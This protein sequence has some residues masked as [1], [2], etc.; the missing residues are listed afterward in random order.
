MIM[1]CIG[2]R[3]CVNTRKM[4]NFQKH[5]AHVNFVAVAATKAAFDL[6]SL[7]PLAT[8]T[9]T[10]KHLTNMY[11][12]YTE[13]V[14]NQFHGLNELYNGTLNE[15][16]HCL[17]STN[18]SSNECYTFRNLMKQEDKLSLVDAMGKAVTDHEEGDNCSIVHCDTLINR[19]QPIKEI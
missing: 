7:I 10:P 15:V 4:K 14:M 11:A 1:D 19:A 18:I 17:Y 13:Q 5:K 9:K 3:A 2:P 12:T 16:H 8:N 6:F